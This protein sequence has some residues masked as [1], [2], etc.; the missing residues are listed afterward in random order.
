[1]K[2]IAFH[3]DCG[4]LF[5]AGGLYFAFDGESNIF[6]YTPGTTLTDIMNDPLLMAFQIHRDRNYNPELSKLYQMIAV[7]H[8]EMGLNAWVEQWVRGGSIPEHL[9]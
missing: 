7:E 2:P 9:L 8:R 4:V 5:S 6:C 1:M 3:E